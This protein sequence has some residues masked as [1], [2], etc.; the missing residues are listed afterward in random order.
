[1]MAKDPRDRYQSFRELI[2]DV[3]AQVA[4]REDLDLGALR[5]RM[6]RG[7]GARRRRP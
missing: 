3:R 7:D 1:M 4:G 2:E 5:E 6:Q